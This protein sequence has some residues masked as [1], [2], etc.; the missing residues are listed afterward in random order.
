MASIDYVTR[1]RERVDKRTGKVKV[2]TQTL[3]RARWRTP[4]GASR[5]QTFD[6]KVDAERHL[7]AMEHS[8]HRGAY[9]DPAAG[10]VTFTEYADEWAAAADW[11]GTSKDS[12][13]FVRARLVDRIGRMQLTSIDQL[14]LKRLRT[15]LGETYA[16]TTVA[17]TMT[18]ATAVMRAAYADGRIGRDPT[19]GV[20]APKARA[21]EADG[22][23][24]PEQVPTR[25]EAQA[26]LACAPLRYRAAVALGIAGLRVGEVLGLEPDKI[27]LET[28]LVTIDQQLQYVDGVLALTTPKAEKVRTIRVPGVVALE[29]R[30]HLRDVGSAEVLGLRDTPAQLLF[31]TRQGAPFHRYSFYRAAWLPAL[32]GAGLE[33]DRFTFHGL[34]HFCASK[35]LAEGAPLTAV[36][37]HLGDTVQTVSRTYV[38]WLR[39]DRDVPADVLDRVLAPTAVEVASGG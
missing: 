4:D 5:S 3:Y 25:A 16:R 17:L 23:V 22:R 37:G 32:R 1:T 12:W 21:G 39:D 28:R 19:L 2:E 36:A 29:L 20:K 8:K 27:E 9:I 11:K 15:S 35:L 34:R 10:R 38:H 7:A 31:S 14:A 33:E 13:R 6:R 18:Y 24:G 26:I 30:R